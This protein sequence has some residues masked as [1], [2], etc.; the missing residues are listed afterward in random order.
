[1]HPL[2][3][4]HLK[5]V[6]L[7]QDHLPNTLEQWQKLL[8]KM[9]FAYVLAEEGEQ[10]QG[11]FE[12][13]NDGILIIDGEARIQQVNSR[14][15]EMLGYTH[16][17]LLGIKFFDLVVPEEREQAKQA[18]GI[19]KLGGK[20]V[21]YERP[22]QRKDG[23]SILMEVNALLVHGGEGDPIY[24]QGTVRDISARKAA[25]NAQRESEQR[26]LNL[27]TT[28]HRQMQE[29]TLFNRVRTV[30]ARE[31]EQD[32]LIQQV[33]EVISSAFGY[34]HVSIYMITDDKLVLRHHVGY[35]SEIRDFLL[36]QGVIG[37][38]ARTGEPALLTD[39]HSDPDYIAGEG[40]IVSE[41]T[42]PLRADGKVVGVLNLE[43]RDEQRLTEAD[44]NLV[45]ALSEQINMALD[46][47]QLYSRLRENKEQYQAVVDHVQ[48][49]IFQYST[50]MGWIFLNAV[51]TMLTGFSIEE[52]LGRLSYDF[53]HPEDHNLLQYHCKTLQENE[54]AHFPA[55]LLTKLGEYRPVDVHLKAIKVSET[56]PLMMSGTITDMSD[57]LRAEQQAILLEA[58][59]Y[60]VEALKVFLDNITHDLRTPLSI[61]NTSLYLVRHKIPETEG[62]ERHLDVMQDQISHLTTMLDDMVQMSQL[63]ED[64]VEYEFMRLDLNG[65]VRDVLVGLTINARAR[66]LTLTYEPAAEDPIVKADPVLLGRVVKNLVLNA[67]QYT[68]SGG[69][70]NVEILVIGTSVLLHVGDTGVGIEAADLERIFERFFKVDKA[71]TAR[72]GGA[73]LGLS[74]VKKIVEGHD[75]TISVESEPGAGSRFTVRLPLLESKS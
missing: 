8:E 58:K 18:F 66:D 14:F 70:I 38:V 21:P 64:I 34:T 12:Q 47:A 61:L 23:T 49:V 33:V 45:L 22:F 1:M 7:D 71:R 57:R 53:F 25:E 74:I 35:E 48:E 4:S 56:R 20:L 16:Q 3:L 29:L 43:G 27:Y 13:H 10:Y 60:T 31:L 46:R 37:R 68:P 50:D 65:L 39:T 30:L 6:G 52:T 44:L 5:A 73:G 75:G 40:N 15:M 72:K 9:S 36:T 28:T 51:W 55:R 69:K 11:V 41:V 63:D 19:I 62:V 17:E 59:T 2:L 26:Y 24:I 42:V 54:T 32:V 67:M